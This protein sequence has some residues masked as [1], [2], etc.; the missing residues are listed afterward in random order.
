MNRGMAFTGFWTQLGKQQ[1]NTLIKMT[2]NSA[3]SLPCANQMCAGSNTNCAIEMVVFADLSKAGFR[4]YQHRCCGYN[5]MFQPFFRAWY[6]H[7]IPECYHFQTFAP[8]WWHAR[9]T[10]HK[11]GKCK[12]WKKSLSEFST[13]DP[14]ADLCRFLKIS[15]CTIIVQMSGNVY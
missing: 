15:R 10:K 5:S 2:R 4:L 14:Q 1:T 13:P 11:F 12:E 8:C 7:V 3:A 6:P 9:K